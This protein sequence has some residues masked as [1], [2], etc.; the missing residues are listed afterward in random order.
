ML[1][2]T[3]D[4]G[5]TSQLQADPD[6]GEALPLK[7]VECGQWRSDVVDAC[8]SRGLCALSPQVTEEPGSI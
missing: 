1:L 4:E 7:S 2:V 5:N 8:E 3:K 6:G